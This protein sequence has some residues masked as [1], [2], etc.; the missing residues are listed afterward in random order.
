MIQIEQRTLHYGGH[1]ASAKAEERESVWSSDFEMG[2]NYNMSVSDRS[3][4]RANLKERA[5]RFHELPPDLV[6]TQLSIA[7][8][9]TA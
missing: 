9:F 7:G 2:V 3:P 1:G 5:L 8:L 4:R 6:T